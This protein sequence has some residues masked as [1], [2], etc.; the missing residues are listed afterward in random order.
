MI[1]SLIFSAR[2]S[3]WKCRY[4]GAKKTSSN[5]TTLRQKNLQTHQIKHTTFPQILPFLF[6][7]SCTIKHSFFFSFFFFENYASFLRLLD[8]LLPTQ[9]LLFPP[10]IRKTCCCCCCC[11]KLRI[12]SD[13]LIN[14]FGKFPL[15]ENLKLSLGTGSRVAYCDVDGFT[16]NMVR[17]CNG[18]TRRKLRI[19][20]SSFASV[21]V[22]KHSNWNQIF[23][24]VRSIKN[25]YFRLEQSVLLYFNLVKLNKRFFFS[26]KCKYCN[27]QSKLQ[28]C[29][30]KSSNICFLLV[31]V[32]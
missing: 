3:T 11:W 16:W 21:R 25:I 28:I 2:D 32:S 31:Y 10:S 7:F 24:C 8:F 15:N 23:D 26:C 12:V 14:G 27:L 1:L 5:S 9:T 6:P 17:F 20:G 22:R 18:C 4:G 30:T 29:S 19:N 13:S